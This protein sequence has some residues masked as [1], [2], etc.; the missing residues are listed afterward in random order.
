MIFDVPESEIWQRLRADRR[1]GWWLKSATN[2]I[3]T[4]RQWR[5]KAVP[6]VPILSLSRTLLPALI[7][8]LYFLKKGRNGIW[9]NVRTEMA[10]RW[11]VISG[12]SRKWTRSWWRSLLTSDCEASSNRKEYEV[13]DRTIQ[14]RLLG[15][16]WSL[17]S[18]HICHRWKSN[19]FSSLCRHVICNIIE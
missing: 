18:N 6:I 8:A 13:Y 4:T 9:I 5:G 16:G 3:E 10:R 17:I 1:H 12:R 2:L 19:Y 14:K 15:I 11:S 7:Y